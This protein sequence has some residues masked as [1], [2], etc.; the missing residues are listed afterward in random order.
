MSPRKG[1]LAW[2]TRHPA[3]DGLQG[4]GDFTGLNLQQSRAEAANL[5]DEWGAENALTLP[6]QVQSPVL[7]SASQEPHDSPHCR[8][9]ALDICPARGNHI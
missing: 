3:E 7:H 1:E 8:K 2:A 9:S 5:S 4:Q 6:W